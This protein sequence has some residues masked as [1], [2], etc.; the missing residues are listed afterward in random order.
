MPRQIQQ[1]LTLDAVEDEILF[2]LVALGTQKHASTYKAEAEAWLADLDAFRAV[3]RSYRTD[4]TTIDVQRVLANHDLDQGVTTFADDLLLAVG[5][6]RQAPRFT[7]FFPK[8][9]SKL[10]EEPLTDEVGR[11]EGWVSSSSDPVLLEHKDALTHL[12]AISRAALTATAGVPIKRL[13]RD[14]RWQALCTSLT[15]RRDALHR[16]L[17]ELAQELGLG[18]D[19]ADLFFRVG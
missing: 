3:D 14:Q 15:E 19:W 10:V 18:R 11:V 1:R 17:A 12:A 8:A 6:D 13:E 16:K 7:A 2:T 4:F 5:K 9:P